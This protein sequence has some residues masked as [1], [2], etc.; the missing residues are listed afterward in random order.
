MTDRVFGI[1]DDEVFFIKK[2]AHR[3]EIKTKKYGLLLSQVHSWLDSD[4]N[5]WLVKDFDLDIK[6]DEIHKELFP[7]WQEYYEVKEKDMFEKMSLDELAK[8]VTTAW[9]NFKTIEEN[10]EVCRYLETGCYEPAVLFVKEHLESMKP[11]I[12]THE[13]NE[14]IEKIKR[15]TTVKL[16]KFDNYFPWVHVENGWLNLETEEFKPH[17]EEMLSLSKMPCSY[18]PDAECPTI[19]RFLIE[20]LSEEEVIVA[21][22]LIGYLLLPHNK[23][24]KAFLLL[25]PQHT[26]KTTF[27]TLLEYFVGL[28]NTSHITL[29]DISIDPFEKIKLYGKWLNTASEIDQSKLEDSS[30]F[31]ELTGEDEISARIMYSQKEVKFRNKAKI[32]IASNDPPRFSKADRVVIDRW[33]I[34]EFNNEPVVK[35]RNLIEK[36]TASEELS[37][38]L[39]MAL[40]GLRLL[41]QDGYFMD[42]SYEEKEEKWRLQSSG[43]GKYFEEFLQR[44]EDSTIGKAELYEHYLKVCKEQQIFAVAQNVFGSEIMA[45]GVGERRIG[46][47]KNRKE[48]YVGIAPKGWSVQVAVT[49]PT[50]TLSLTNIS[51]STKE[52][53][54][55]SDVSDVVPAESLGG[56]ST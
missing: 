22:K 26:G 7:V 55:V 46:S 35:D 37:G 10:G 1:T 12:K 42:E 9:S 50:L 4:Y 40:E 41:E 13:V 18:N 27:R 49:S 21:K 54:K 3:L 16:E 48:V 6:R 14:V 47:G 24:K 19:I 17:N 38:L 28:H 20:T 43:I 11:N 53:S 32:V 56:R 39:N 45:L 33:V 8:Y 34:L 5:R 2:P 44:K 52:T 30:S 51:N 36:M 15:R 29:H 31:K 25:G 23:Y